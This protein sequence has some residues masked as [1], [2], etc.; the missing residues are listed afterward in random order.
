MFQLCADGAGHVCDRLAGQRACDATRYSVVDAGDGGDFEEGE[1]DLV[2]RW[3]RERADD[4]AVSRV[5]VV[6]G[7]LR[8]DHG[9]GDLDRCFPN[10]VGGVGGG[11]VG[12]EEGRLVVMDKRVIAQR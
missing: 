8:G 9:D 1:R 11:F 10:D 2:A 3:D 12:D 6:D 4:M 5:F 7:E